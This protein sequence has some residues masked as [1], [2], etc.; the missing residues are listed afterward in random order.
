MP[1]N[2]L[3]T[4]KNSDEKV[5]LFSCMSV[6]AN[7]NNSYH[8]VTF[9]KFISVTDSWSQI[10]IHGIT[11]HYS[12][13]YTI[14]IDQ[15]HC[16]LTYHFIL[17]RTLLRISNNTYTSDWIM[18]RRLLWCHFPRYTSLDFQN[19]S[20]KQKHKKLI[21]MEICWSMSWGEN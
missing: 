17:R 12:Y 21:L 1:D 10:L 7:C 18:N 20:H 3:D 11:S 6:L 14:T 4:Y 15:Q 13:G 16:R 2:I 19:T 5:L 8:H 9:I